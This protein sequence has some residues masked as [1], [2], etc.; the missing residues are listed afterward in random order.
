MV[1]VRH[2]YQRGARER[3]S[4]ELYELVKKTLY[5]EVCQGYG[6][7]WEKQE[8]QAAVCTPNRSKDEGCGKVYRV[9]TPSSRL[10]WWCEVEH[11]IGWTLLI[12]WI[13]Y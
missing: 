11:L 7:P 12:Q 4:L 2:K 1:G 5:D 13:I 8:F 9:T 10:G 3:V 6:W